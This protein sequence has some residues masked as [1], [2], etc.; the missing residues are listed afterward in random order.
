MKITIKSFAITKDYFPNNTVIELPESEET[1]TLG[2]FVDY[3]KAENPHAIILLD[4][5]R[6]AIGDEFAERE[7]PITEGAEICFLPPSSGG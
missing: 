3:L 4:N 2:S 6:F 5:C 7:D 1:A